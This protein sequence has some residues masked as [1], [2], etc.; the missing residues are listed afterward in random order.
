MIRAQAR[1]V[2]DP[3]V[4]D[5]GIVDVTQDGLQDLTLSN[6]GT[7]DVELSYEVIDDC[8]GCFLFSRPSPFVL[9]QGQSLGAVLRFRPRQEGTATATISFSSS[10]DDVTALRILAS[11]VGRDGRR[12][13][14]EV[15][16]DVVDF[17]GGVVPIG[18]P[19]FDRFD[20][21]ST[22]ELDLLIDSIRIE[23]ATAPYRITTSTP[24]P[25]NPGRLPPGASA[26]VSI[27]V[28]IPFGSTATTSASVLID[29]NVLDEKNV[30]GTPGRVRVPITSIGNLPPVAVIDAPPQVEPF[31]RV[32]LDG[33]GSFDPDDPPDLPLT[34]T[35]D[36][37]EAPP[38]SQARLQSRTLPQSAFLADLTGDYRVELAVRDQLGLVGTAEQLIQAR[39]D[40]GIRIELTWDHPDSDVDLHLVRD[41]GAFC[42]CAGGVPGAPSDVHYRCR[43]PNWYPS[44]PGANPLLDVDD[45]DGFGPEVI[46]LEGEGDDKVIPADRFRIEVH[47]FNDKDAISSFPTT[48]SNATVRV[49]LSGR[50]VAEYDRALERRG[51]RWIVA[52]LEWPSAQFTEIDRAFDGFGCGIF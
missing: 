11:G 22:G 10:N 2:A 7:R 37:I 38:G 32:D 4:I 26:A 24:T 5:F 21:F 40:D 46:T 33:A 28:E 6:L 8:G 48:V 1:V 16:P 9:A 34:Y 30:P 42:D 29:T 50:K 39:P 51:V 3:S 15:D 25:T 47:Y 27:R 52:E 18:A 41:G 20:I 13:D 19:A 44:A 43:S 17:G 31:T 12:P 14:I 36:L 45:D 49:F 35:W 23:P